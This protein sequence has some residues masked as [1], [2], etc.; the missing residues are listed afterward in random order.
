MA[1]ERTEAP[2]PKRRE[3]A[4]KKGQSGKSQE[5]VS[6]GVLLVAVIALR[7]LGPH[8]WSDMAAIVRDGLGQSPK[9]DLTPDSAM[10]LGRGA[11]LRMLTT[12]APL[13]ALLAVASIVL[14]IGQ[15]GLMLSGS[16]LK[17]K[18]GAMNPAA[19][20]KRIF[21]SADG[22]INLGKALAK[23]TVTAV[24]VTMTMRGQMAEIA[25]LSQVI[26]PAAGARL[27]T[28][29]FDIALR[30]AGVLFLVAVADFAWQRRK[31][32]TSL[33]M[34][35]EEVRQE[36]KESDG[37]PQV[38]AAIR[39]RRQALMNRMMAAVPQATVVIAN[40][41][42]YAVALRYDRKMAAPQC[43]AKGVDDLALRI[44]ALAEEHE[45]PVVENPPLARAL[46]ASVEVDQTIPTEHFKAVA[47]VIG[48]VMR[49]RA[50]R[51]WR[52]SSRAA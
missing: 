9:E 46:Y 17:P 19:N 27:E 49:L 16:S 29:G 1:G 8:I 52:A 32:M 28:L 51:G 21:L 35:K 36:A 47:Q 18:L 7:Q 38:K 12:L 44:R 37:D 31:F 20:A 40:P 11:T 33:R 10:A 4:T 48:Y 25:N 34:T 5:L 42:H 14:N 6:I 24:V 41:T 50:R 26:V 23:M 45:V 3:E 13:L 43:V 39:R 15:T 2:T 30:G 22:A